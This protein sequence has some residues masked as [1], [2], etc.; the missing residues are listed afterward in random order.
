MQNHIACQHSLSDFSFHQGQ[1][2]CQGRSYMETSKLFEEIRAHVRRITSPPNGISQSKLASDAGIDQSQISNFVRE[3]T[4]MTL[5]NACRVLEVL[6]YR[7]VPPEEKIT[8]E[9]EESL[10]AELA[11]T[12]NSYLAGI[13][14]DDIRYKVGD[15]ITGVAQKQSRQKAAGE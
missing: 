11:H 8:K 9:D 10:R 13:V 6:G 5:A 14:E 15:I 3:K 4:G 7:L 1:I 12:V 2:L